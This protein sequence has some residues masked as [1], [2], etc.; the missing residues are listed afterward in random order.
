MPGPVI[1]TH[2]YA[3][4]TRIIV[5]ERK[6]ALAEVMKNVLVSCL[7]QQLFKV[8]VILLWWA[9]K[10]TLKPMS[11]SKYLIPQLVCHAHK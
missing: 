6:T 11:P 9:K 10:K 5:M 7:N 2:I 3:I 1:E 4:I 8:E